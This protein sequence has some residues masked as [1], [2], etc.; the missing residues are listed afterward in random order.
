M[1]KNGGI[2]MTSLGFQHSDDVTGC[3]SK[4]RDD[5]SEF[6]GAKV[7]FL[8]DINH[9]I[10]FKAGGGKSRNLKKGFFREEK[11]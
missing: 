10:S 2:L 9:P 4:S 5:G 3:N 7:N 11:K 6:I 1:S 8:S